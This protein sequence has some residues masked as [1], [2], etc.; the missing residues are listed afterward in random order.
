[1]D[2]AHLAELAARPGTWGE[3]D[4]GLT[5]RQRAE[6]RAHARAGFDQLRRE[7]AVAA[8]MRSAW[9]AVVVAAAAAA[10]VGVTP[11][12]VDRLLG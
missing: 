6:S 1:M 2:V 12:V 11:G 3:R 9:S 8:R 10:L 4:G 5:G 7:V